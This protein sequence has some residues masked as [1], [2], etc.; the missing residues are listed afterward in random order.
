MADPQLSVPRYLSAGEA[1][2]AWLEHLAHE[3]RLAPNTLEAYGRISRLYL[4]FLERHRGGPQ[5][6]GDLGTVTAA[7]VR[8]HLAERRS[9]DHPLAARSISQTLSA[10]RA[11]HGFLDRRCGT[12]APQLALVRGP[13][14]KTSLPRP[15]SED[16]ARGLLQESDADPDAEAWE[17]A[18][19]RAV[20]TLLY[21]CGLRISEGLSLSRS[22]APLPETL[23]ITGKGGKTRLAPVLPAVREAVD[24][25]LAL[26]P[27]P[28]A[29][30]DALF[31]AR[32][33]GPL[34]PRHVQAMVQRLRGRLGLPATATPHAL[35]HS[36]A[37]HLLGAGADLRSIQELLG[38]ASLSTTQK[39]TAVDAQRLLDAY[40]GAHPRR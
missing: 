27:F 12:P 11:F 32:R 17:A 1:L 33:G 31:R 22:D 18:R 30:A 29:P 28:L 16:Q 26:Q 10:I 2:A 9:G 19:D 14:I 3:R 6:L 39:Y 8:A 34:T 20:L 13:R 15:V 38:H 37:T 7:E 40:S 35:R 25:Y 36:F 23:R 24:G 4:A 21:G 5:R